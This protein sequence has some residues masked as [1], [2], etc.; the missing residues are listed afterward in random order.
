MKMK[1]KMKMKE[2]MSYDH[3]L[4]D[5]RPSCVPDIRRSPFRL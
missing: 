3:G 5:R 2:T 4:G 1:M